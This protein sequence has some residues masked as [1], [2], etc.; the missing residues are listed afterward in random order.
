MTKKITKLMLNGQEYEIREYQA[1]RQPWANTIAYWK[2]N[3]NLNDEMWN[4]N[5]TIVWSSTTVNY[6]SLPWDNNIQCAEIYSSRRDDGIALPVSIDNEIFVNN[7]DFTFGWFINMPTVGNAEEM[8]Y[9]EPSSS[10][11]ISLWI[12][13]WNFYTEA[14]WQWR[15]NTTANLSANTWYSVIWTYESSTYTW[16]YYVNGNLIDPVTKSQN[17]STKSWTNKAYLVRNN[18]YTLMSNLVLE[19]NITRNQ[20]EISLFHDTFKSLYWIS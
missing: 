16:K 7:V 6:T 2:L 12:R 17:Y 8:L 18:D 15:W 10:W 14:I 4:Y 19:K 3:G 11:V 9:L 13:N 1:G 5:W 20:Q